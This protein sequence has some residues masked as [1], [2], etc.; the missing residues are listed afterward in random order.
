MDYDKV[1]IFFDEAME[2]LNAHC[3]NSIT[4]MDESNNM[5]VV[6][7]KDSKFLLS[8]TLFYTIF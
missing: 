2:L 4:A 8:F 3:I 1:E 7:N 6:K 5:I